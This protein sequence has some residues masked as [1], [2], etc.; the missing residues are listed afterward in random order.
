MCSIFM[1]KEGA[2]W[3]G[4]YVEENIVREGEQAFAQEYRNI[5]AVI[6][7]RKLQLNELKEIRNDVYESSKIY[8]EKTKVAHDKMISRKEFE[9]GQKVF[10]FNTRMKLFPGKLRYHQVGP[11]IVTNVFSHGVVEIGT[12]KTAKE[13]KVNSHS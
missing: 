7:H 2:W 8:K 4:R 6:F 5:K 13:Q 3:L 1:G 11:F 9:L 10:L 12:M